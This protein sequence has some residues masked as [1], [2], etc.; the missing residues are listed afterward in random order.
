M[1]QGDD[2]VH[3]QNS[4]TL[5]DRLT[6]SRIGNWDSQVFTDDDHSIVFH[7][8]TSSCLLEVGRVV[9]TMVREEGRLVDEYGRLMGN[10]WGIKRVLSVIDPTRDGLR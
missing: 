2:N 1:E 6:N 4:L 8:G 10:Y 5:M 7:Q 9:G 3:I